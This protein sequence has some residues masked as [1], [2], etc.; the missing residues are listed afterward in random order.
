MSI[1][2][3]I[4]IILNWLLYILSTRN[5]TY[6]NFKITVIKFKPKYY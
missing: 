3:I 5:Y 1:M 2:I 4:N 6:H